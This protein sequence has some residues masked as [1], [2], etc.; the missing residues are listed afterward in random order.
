MAEP[1][2]AEPE[3]AEPALAEPEL[4]DPVLLPKFTVGAV[5]TA[6]SFSTVKFALGSKP[7]TLAVMLVGNWRTVVL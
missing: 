7:N 3:F 1:E 5:L 2:L 4:A 6:R